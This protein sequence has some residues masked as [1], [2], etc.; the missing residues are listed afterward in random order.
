MYACPCVHVCT[1]VC[2]HI[3]TYVF[4]CMCSPWTRDYFLL[5]YYYYDFIYYFTSFLD[6]FSLLTPQ[7][8]QSG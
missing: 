3:C 5:H 1:H 4:V 6:V 8:I 7:V 2:I